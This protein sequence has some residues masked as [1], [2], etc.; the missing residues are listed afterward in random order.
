MN[1]A[2]SIDEKSFRRI[3]TRNLALP[4][5]TGVLGTGLFVV[6]IVYLLY[7]LNWVEHTE[8]VISQANENYRL[9][10]D[11]QSGLRGYLIGG[12]EEYLT[13]YLAARTQLDAQMQS[14][15]D[16]VH[17]NPPQVERIRQI[18][19][20]QQEWLTSASAMLEQRQASNAPPA[21]ATVGRGKLM[22][23]IRAQ[24]ND[25]I[26]VEQQ[27]RHDRNE[28]ANF[29]AILTISLYV[30][31]NLSF[32]AILAFFGRRELLG[33]S[34]FYGSLLQQQQ[35]VT[36]QLQQQAWQREG[37]S[38]LA[39]RIIGQPNI[40]S[41]GRTALTFLG[42]Y[43]DLVVGAFYVRQDDGSL[44]RVADY[45]FAAEHQAQAQTFKDGA[46]LVGEVALERRPRVMSGLN[47]GYLRV[48]SGLG[49]DAPL[50][51]MLAPIENEGE[52]NGVIELGFLKTL[53]V[54]EQTFVA[55]ITEG[56]GTSIEVA[57]Y[58]QRLHEVLRETQQLN[59]ELQAQQEE[60]KSA[61]EEL[62]DQA[63]LIQ[64]SQA[65]LE[66]QQAELEQTNEQLNEQTQYLT[67][68]RDELDERN[69]ALALA[70]SELE[71]R[72]DE[73][74]RASRY[75]S[76]FLANMSHELRTPLNS[77]LILSRLLA[78]N[79]NGN[80]DEQQIKHA[81]LIYSSGKDL[82]SLINDILD[83]SKVEAGRLELRPEET[84]LPHL[85]ASLESLFQPQAVEKQLAFKVSIA[86]NAPAQFVSD[87]QR[88]EQIL[89]NLLSNAFKFTSQGTVSL[90]IQPADGGLAFVVSD[91]GIGISQEQQSIIFDAFRQADGSTNRLF[92]GTGL[93]LS[94]SRNLAEVL[95]GHIQVDSQP[96]RGSQF[97]LWLPLNY[98]QAVT[99]S[100]PTSAPAARDLFIRPEAAAHTPTSLPAGHAEP[101]FPDDRDRS[102][103]PGRC[104]LVIEDEAKFAQILYDLAHEMNYRCLV[105]H[106][107][108]E[109]FALLA[110]QAPDAIL[111]D[112]RLPDEP[113]LSLLQ[114][115][116]E[117][118]HT[119][120]IPVH[121]ISTDDRTELALHLG[122]IG[123]AQKPTTRESLVEVF[124]RLEA[125][126]TQKVK[127]VLVVEG[128]AEQRDSIS[129]LV[130]DVDIEVTA[131][132][133]GEHALQLLRQTTFDCMI[134][135]L[136]L[137]DMHGNELLT[138]MASETIDSY[139]PVIVYV[140]RP[141]SRSEEESLRQHS[142]SIIIKGA[143]SPER[144]LDEVTLFL[145]KVE[146]PFA[147]DRQR[148]LKSARNRDQVFEN[149]QVLVVDD[150]MRNVYALISALDEK[151][152]K[153]VSASN[154]QEALD[155]L[156]KNPDVDLV[157]MDVMMP[158]MDGFEAT[159]RIRQD[160]RWHK[161]P[162]LAV[163]A[164]AMKDDQEQCLKAGASDYLAKPLDLERL[165]SL[166]RVW[167]PRRDI[168]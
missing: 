119:R 113:G 132:A 136:K 41:I 86:A 72:A 33:L 121:V 22:E 48:T 82:L 70:R 125:K 10:I 129:Q 145:H 12:E 35:V 21:S 60:L 140:S 149:R 158:V 153:V 157:L 151:G 79:R 8:R 42:H 118:P 126:L 55:S 130:D 15:H 143:R 28:K 168:F 131:V 111:L 142:R 110:E 156:D 27:L 163:T 155:K 107:S 93:G 75:K 7:V 166:I 25:L 114:R 165:F 47:T 148:P 154:G 1:S 164:K 36:E 61:N 19:S 96:G 105:A 74:Q 152:I 39:E 101:S 123:Y 135:D 150:D 89:K 108:T 14:L 16:L 106:S 11:L 63:R 138:R 77:S 88:V 161:L 50:A 5:G 34:S 52:V 98:A 97:T 146:A 141:L 49:N 37:Q 90:H 167:L 66:Q 54:R 160:P 124:S 62:E 24:F 2:A 100:S 115:L 73:L 147:N 40:D 94:I 84:A 4:V 120:H 32:S 80:L 127:R 38:Q 43:L 81:E 99:T 122:A 6:L 133:D 59:E 91:S 128:D 104:V 23:S 162:I 117:D 53:S 9:T 18:E 3:L 57:R 58:R 87:S 69:H 20:L 95:G 26:A 31:F 65:N 85:A 46:G 112:M 76:E 78:D 134:T 30:L 71:Q 68:Q 83:L 109:A 116:K 144:L 51:V 137:P 56:L 103:M 29:T 64:E 92:G 17:D 67:R 44:A 102:D 139:P 13:P 45:G 159:R